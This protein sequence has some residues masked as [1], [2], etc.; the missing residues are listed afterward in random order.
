MQKV[1]L[2]LLNLFRRPALIPLKRGVR[3]LQTLLNKADFEHLQRL[4][5]SLP[6]APLLARQPRF[7]Y[8][9]LSSYIA[10][11]F[12][13]TA[14]LRVLLH[15]FQFLNYHL[16]EVFF[17]AL[18][19]CPVLWRERR[20]ADVFTITI[21]YP[22][23]AGFEAELS[24]N[25]VYNGTVLQVV[26][27]VIAP[28]DVLG[29]VSGSILLFSQVQGIK[30]HGLLKYVTR[31]LHEIPPAILLVNAAY[32]LAAA[33]GISRAAGVSTASQISAGPTN[34]FDYSA[35]WHGLKGRRAAASDALLLP[36]PTP[37][38]PITQIASN[39]R[40]RNL[41]K[42]HYKQCLREVVEREARTAFGLSGPGIA[43]AVQIAASP[44]LV[45][46]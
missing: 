44:I 24:L 34:Y 35:F 7:V 11:S 37:E 31:T 39:H 33:M 26:G 23:L 18:A 16:G 42:R 25:F 29:E 43:A 45:S 6:L 12:D 15:H 28:A 19:G 36:I 10:A 20:G 4:I 41:R 1:R 38:K 9:Y 5:A 22:P 8:K 2:I 17:T 14:R 40:S 13:R 30:N 3:S 32:G 27:F 21:S 46:A